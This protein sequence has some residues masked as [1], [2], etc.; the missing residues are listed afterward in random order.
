M[1][2][3]DFGVSQQPVQLRYDA[4]LDAE[5]LFGTVAPDSFFDALDGRVV[6]CG[7]RSWRVIVF[8]VS[9]GAGHR[10]VQ[11][12]LRGSCDYA[13]ALRLNG[14]EGVGQ[15]IRLVKNWLANGLDNPNII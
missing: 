4:T 9:E 15:V 6:R 5:N 13:L 11:L 3:E 1:R 10:W 12:A 2:L 14:D 7:S 8:S